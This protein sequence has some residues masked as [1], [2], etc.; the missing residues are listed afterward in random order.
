MPQPFHVTKAAHV[1]PQE[2]EE[3]MMV[4]NVP[5]MVD[6]MERMGEGMIE[7]IDIL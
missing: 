7:R 4:P 1:L 3:K 5:Q 6:E 2:G